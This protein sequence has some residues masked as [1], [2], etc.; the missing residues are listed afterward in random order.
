M[1]GF[2]YDGHRLPEHAPFPRS[3]YAPPEPGAAAMGTRTPRCKDCRQKLVYIE[4]AETG[5]RMP[6]DPDQRHGDGQRHLVV[7]FEMNDHVYGRLVPRASASR[8]G[9]K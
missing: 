5:K 6:C 4:M 2:S 1:K 3:K 7:R 8:G 9:L